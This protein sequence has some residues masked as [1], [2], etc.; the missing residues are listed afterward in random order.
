MAEEH[1]IL[2]LI[3]RRFSAERFDPDRPLDEE[4]I[5]ELV[6]DATCA[7]SSFNMQHWRFVAVRRPEDKSRLCEAAHGQKQVED[8]AVTF[9]VLGDVRAVETL[10]AIMKE[11]VERNALPE[12]KASAWVRMA[13]EIY[14]DE[15][16]AR[17]E[18]IRSA[19]LAAMTMILA[20]E[21]RGLRT[22]ALS[23]FDPVRVRREFGIEERHLPPPPKT[24]EG[25]DERHRG[26]PPPPLGHPTH[27]RQGGQRDEH[28]NR[29]PVID[30]R[31]NRHAVF[32]REAHGQPE[33]EQPRSDPGKRC[34]EF[35]QHVGTFL[36]M[37]NH[38]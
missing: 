18:A 15:V 38:T 30:D 5:L 25:G 34:E 1:P 11:A 16:M 32:H 29:R 2:E 4:Q 13:D 26:Q 24:R 3:R 10:P 36:F 23:G 33:D 37:G 17:D 6:R 22:G 27:T 8:A 9:I 28:S 19:T 21:A 7:P 20:A 31:Q 14:A 35:A 12:G